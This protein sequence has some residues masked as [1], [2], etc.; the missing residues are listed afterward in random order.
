MRHL[1][2]GGARAQD[3][4][5]F[6][7]LRIDD[8]VKHAHGAACKTKGQGSLDCVDADLDVVNAANDLLALARSV[9]GRQLPRIKGSSAKQLQDATKSATLHVESGKKDHLLR[10][11][12]IDADFGLDVP[13]ELRKAFGNVVGAKVHFSLGVRDPNRP[14][15]V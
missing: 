10:L 2:R 3:G 6:G 8:W 7:E 13:K 12:E 14:V 5:G 1:E 11:L 9:S 15:H 4:N